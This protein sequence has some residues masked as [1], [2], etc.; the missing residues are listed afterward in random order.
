MTLEK[1]ALSGSD[2]LSRASPGRAG[3]EAPRSLLR[4]EL[5]YEG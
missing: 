1:G 2:M 3:T 4:P 5:A